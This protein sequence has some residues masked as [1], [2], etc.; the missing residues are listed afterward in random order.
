[1]N[2][3]RRPA[4]GRARPPA[5]LSTILS[6]SLWANGRARLHTCRRR[7]GQRERARFTRRRLA[8]FRPLAIQLRNRPRRS[9]RSAGFPSRRRSGESP[10]L[11]GEQLATSRGRPRELRMTAQGSVRTGRLDR[12]KPP[13]RETGLGAEPQRRAVSM[14]LPVTRALD[15]RSRHISSDAYSEGMCLPSGCGCCRRSE[16]RPGCGPIRTTKRRAST[17]SAH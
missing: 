14:D 16:M 17:G 13:A 15:L 11:T 9:E 2:T 5:A 4:P 3:S 1:M 10:G 12:R 8:A 7:C 6:T